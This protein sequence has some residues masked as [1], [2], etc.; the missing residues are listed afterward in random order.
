MKSKQNRPL[1]REI[2][3]AASAVDFSYPGNDRKEDG[4]GDSIRRL[5]LGGLNERRY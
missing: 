1:W 5:G 3:E 4:N 2:P